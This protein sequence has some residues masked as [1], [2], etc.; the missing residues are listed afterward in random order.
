MCT[1][2]PRCIM[3]MQTTLVLHFLLMFFLSV[4]VFFTLRQSFASCSCLLTLHCSCLLAPLPLASCLLA[5]GFCYFACLLLCLDI[6][7]ELDSSHFSILRFVPKLCLTYSCSSQGM[8]ANN[9]YFLN[10]VKYPCWLLMRMY[11]S[12][13][14][15]LAF[16]YSMLWFSR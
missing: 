11:C 2:F 14:Y 9:W 5:L 7:Q 4:F 3:L 15:V 13:V 16:N 10:R 6:V 1:E 8:R 12:L